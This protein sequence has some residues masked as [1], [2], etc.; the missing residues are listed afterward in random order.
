MSDSDTVLAVSGIEMAY[1]VSVTRCARYLAGVRCYQG[2]WYKLA[3]AM[4]SAY[5]PPTRCPGCPILGCGTEVLY[6]A[7]PYTCCAVLRCCQALCPMRAGR[8]ELGYAPMVGGVFQ[9]LPQDS[10]VLPS[11]ETLEPAM[12]LRAGLSIGIPTRNALR[13]TADTLPAYTLAMG[14]AGSDVEYGHT[15]IAGCD[16]AYGHTCIAGSDIAYECHVTGFD[17]TALQQHS[18]LSPRCL[19]PRRFLS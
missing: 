14:Y 13:A 7:M 5:A 18:R 12:L 11:P 10:L 16:I 19:S 1:T 6:G 15:G 17:R 2:A 9:P 3:A 4:V 8:I